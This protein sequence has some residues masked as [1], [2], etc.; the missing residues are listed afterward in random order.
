[1]EDEE[2]LLYLKKVRLTQEQN[3]FEIVVD[4]LGANRRPDVLLAL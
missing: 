2:Q 1:M 3:T 4:H